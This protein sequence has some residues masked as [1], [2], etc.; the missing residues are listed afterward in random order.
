MDE[1]NPFVGGVI[2]FVDCAVPET[3]GC[4]LDRTRSA[5]DFGAGF[6]TAVSSVTEG[7]FG[8][9][10]LSSLAEAAVSTAF[11]RRS[12]LVAGTVLITS[13]A[14]LADARLGGRAPM[15]ILGIAG[16]MGCTGAVGRP[17]GLFFGVVCRGGAI[18]EDG[19]VGWVESAS[20][21]ACEVEGVSMM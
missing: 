17:A 15:G 4:P 5:Q 8:L 20:E 21:G 12:V 3:V 18:A 1:P 13:E 9:I 16:M 2:S 6:K 11:A 14:A 10:V 19:V 7:V